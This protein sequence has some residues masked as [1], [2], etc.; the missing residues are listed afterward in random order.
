[1][2]ARSAATAAQRYRQAP[3]SRPAVQAF[4]YRGALVT[5]SVVSFQCCGNL[6][7][8]RLPARR[9]DRKMP[10]WL[11]VL[12]QHTIISDALLHCK[13]KSITKCKYQ[14]INVMA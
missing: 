14:Y 11:A 4:E 5:S 7:A 1:M 3:L 9:D 13:I 12:L 2:H 8:N 6:A 10:D